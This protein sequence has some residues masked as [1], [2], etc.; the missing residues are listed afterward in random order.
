VGLGGEVSYGDGDLGDE[1]LADG[2]DVE[3]QLSRDGNDGRAVGDGSANELEDRLVVRRGAV[4][5][6]Q[7][8]LVLEDDDVVQ[9]HDFDG[10]KMFTRLRL[11]AGFVSGD[12]K[13]RSV[14][15]G[16]TRQHSAHENVV[17]GAVDE[18]D[19]ALQPVLSSTALALAR[20]VDLLLALVRSV[21]CRAR[22]L[23]VVA[24]VDLGVGVTELDG[25][26]AL[27]LVLE[28]DR[29]DTGDGLDNGTLSVGDVTDGSNVDGGLAGDNF[30]GQRAEGGEVDGGWVGLLAGRVLAGR[31]SARCVGA[32]RELR[33]LDRQGRFL[34]LLHGRLWLCVLDLLLLGYALVIAVLVLGLGIHAGQMSG[35]DRCG[36]GG[37]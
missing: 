1:L 20:R 18:R 8:D 23:S 3:L 32:L 11:G 16:G 12:Q 2:V 30:G 33:S 22:A 27:E 24:L 35:G 13:Q 9:L 21:T 29:L 5:P 34:G 19:V 25:N 14:H 36:G 6:H 31:S 4:F 26:V 17:T 37:R 10:G 28:T 7:V 15:D